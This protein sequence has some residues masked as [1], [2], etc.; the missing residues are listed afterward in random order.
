MDTAP[1]EQSALTFF[2]S[3]HTEKKRLQL[4]RT[5]SFS[6]KLVWNISEV[7]VVTST[8]SLDCLV[9]ARYG[10]ESWKHTRRQYA[11]CLCLWYLQLLLFTCTLSRSMTFHNSNTHT[12]SCI[13][14]NNIYCWTIS[15]WWRGGRKYFK[16]KKASCTEKYIHVE[17]PMVNTELKTC[18]FASWAY[19][20]KWIQ[21]HLSFPP[22]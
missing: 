6:C 7:Y 4:G 5:A 14:V 22:F 9:V 20:C 19:L 3:I 1:H 11:E 15:S 21:G 10:E 16:E 17:H 12:I 2:H 8:T 18:A 13:V